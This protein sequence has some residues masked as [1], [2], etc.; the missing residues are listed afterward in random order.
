[1]L[2]DGGID[3]TVRG[4]IKQFEMAYAELM[5]SDNP[6]VNPHRPQKMQVTDRDFKLAPR[7]DGQGP[8]KLPVAKGTPLEYFTS[9]DPHRPLFMKCDDLVENKGHQFGV[10]LSADDKL[11]LREFL[12]TM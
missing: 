2:P 11:A 3:Y 4:R 12:K 10:N 5:M 6:D 7:E 1:M 9:S 8:I